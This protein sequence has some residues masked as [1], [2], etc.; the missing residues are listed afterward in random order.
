[1][2]VAQLA[3]LIFTEALKAYI[4][5]HFNKQFSKYTNANNS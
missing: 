3:K 2:R 5:I 1:M 4:H